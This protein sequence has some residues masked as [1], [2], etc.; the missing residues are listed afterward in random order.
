MEKR[1]KE[2]G[3]RRGGRKGK[4]KR[5]KAER[6]KECSVVVLYPG[7]SLMLQQL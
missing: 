2:K 4:E 6:G 7:S 3:N 1:E 5:G